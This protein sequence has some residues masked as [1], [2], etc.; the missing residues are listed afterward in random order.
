MSLRACPGCSRHVRAVDAACPFCR[1]SL[2]NMGRLVALGGAVAITASCALVAPVY[3]A[4]APAPST[5]PTATAPAPQPLYGAMAP[6]AGPPTATPGPVYG[7]SP[8]SPTPTPPNQVRPL[9]GAVAPLTQ[10]E[11]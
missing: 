10:T 9:Y 11:S 4:P 8:P 3:G 2:P 5:S 7:S 6:S 1:T